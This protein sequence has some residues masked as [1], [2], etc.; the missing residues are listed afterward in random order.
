MAE[1]LTKCTKQKETELALKDEIDVLHAQ[2]DVAIAELEA[3]REET[4]R[5]EEVQANLVVVSQKAQ[6][7]EETLQ[8][9]TRE[10]SQCKGELLSRSNQI[11]LLQSLLE[12]EKLQATKK[13]QE[14]EKQEFDLK[15]GDAAI[16]F[17]NPCST[18]R[19]SL[20][21]SLQRF[22]IS[23]LERTKR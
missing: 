11:V 14:N 20:R 5:L 13:M 22:R 15:V 19:R 4:K 23:L 17:F 3:E 2:N 7:H 12:Q 18:R 10:L 21:K 6:Q 1:L 16:F 8:S 9:L